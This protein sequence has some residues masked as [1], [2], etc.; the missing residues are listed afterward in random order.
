MFEGSGHFPVLDAA[1]RWQALFFA[2]L[3]DAEEQAA[4]H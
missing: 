3:H 1:D 2:F 4:R